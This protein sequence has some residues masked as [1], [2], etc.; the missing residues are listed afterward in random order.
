[1]EVWGGS[2]LTSRGVV[3]G[4]LDAW[5]YS[6]PY[7]QAHAG[8]DIYYASS[9]ATGRISRLL[10][11]D[12]AGHGQTV[13]STA[14]D[15][16][17]LMRR[18]VNRLDQT[19]FVRLL[20]QQFAELPRT[21]AFATAIVT[22][23]FEPSRR[24]TVCNAGHPRPLLYRAEQRQWDFLGTQDAGRRSAPSNIPLGLF[25][26]AEYE[27]FDVELQPG[28]ILLSYTDALIE[29]RDADGEM[30]G[31]DGLLRITRL[32]GD[33]EPQKLTAALL[34]EIEARYPENLSEDDVTVLVVRAN[35]RQLRFS[36]GEKLR[37][38][39]RFTKA[40]VS[41]QRA[42]FPDA[43]LANIGGGDYS[44]AGPALARAT[45]R[46]ELVRR[47][48]QTAVA[49]LGLLPISPEKT[50]QL[51]KWRTALKTREASFL[52][53]G[54]RRPNESAPRR[55]RQRTAHANPPHAHLREVGHF[56]PGVRAHQYVHRLGTYRR[57]NGLNIGAPMN[58]RGVEHV[59]AGFR[60]C[61][62]T[63]DRLPQR[64]WMP[65]QKALRA[66]H[67]QHIFA[68]IVD[69]R[70]RRFHPLHGDRQIV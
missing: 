36:L 19:E 57:D 29:S 14:A 2:Q 21:G 62:E 68:R 18:F 4:G 63:P 58:A 64:I 35:G 65:N 70:A 51:C 30:L 43:K 23:F 8:G 55:P 20:N 42:P 28:D 26:G 54:F 33:V 34:G 15:L 61:L 32:L 16:R 59:R 56:Q 53:D 1:M 46:R 69:G 67:Q 17:T 41:G 24:L 60:I 48:G 11:A 38:L 3:F 39:G 27:Q 47:P 10:L 66:P 7:G 9:C 22:T 25:G 5:V 6:K 40:L 50:I 13:A 12:V 37:A 52:S 44:G 31:E 49:P 45:V